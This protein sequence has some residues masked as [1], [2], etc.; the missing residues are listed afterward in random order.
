MKTIRIFQTA[1]VAGMVCFATLAN[2]KN[3]SYAGTAQLLDVDDVLAAQVDYVTIGATMPYA[4]DT[5][6]PNLDAWRDTLAAVGIDATAEIKTNWFV[7]SVELAGSANNDAIKV[8]WLDTGAYLLT[9]KTSIDVKVGVNSINNTC[10]SATINKTVYVLPVPNA[11]FTTTIKV[12]PCDSTT[13]TVNYDVAGI[14]RKDVKYDLK[15]RPYVS[16]SDINEL[17]NSATPVGTG[18]SSIGDFDEGI[19]YDDALI[20]YDVDDNG[21]ESGRI[22]IAGLA[23]GWIYTV[24]IT[25]IS[26]QISRKSDVTVNPSN[27]KFSFAVVP[28]PVG[29]KIDHVKNIE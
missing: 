11:K 2:A 20:K 1:L 8:S 12:L 10:D 23:K 13:Y 28:E 19:S 15:R 22:P 9:V 7:D 21:V 16:G 17:D 29:T 4:T 3:H 14:G 5:V 25:E 27:L 24:T 26:D 6:Q 18:I